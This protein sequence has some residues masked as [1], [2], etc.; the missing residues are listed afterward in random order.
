MILRPLELGDESAANRAQKILALEDFP[1]L[2]DFR[3][4]EAFDAY[5]ARVDAFNAGGRFSEG[6][7]PGVFLVAD[8][9]GEIVGRL[10]VRYELSDYLREFG[11]HIGYCVLPPHRRRGYAAQMLAAGLDLLWRR[12]LDEALV[13]CD[14]DNGGSIGVVEKAGGS[15][16]KTIPGEQ[17]GDVA[18]RHYI[19]HRDADRAAPGRI[20]PGSGRAMKGVPS[21]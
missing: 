10:S 4:G 21:T 6:G 19:F 9:D 7:V 11:G 5:V 2:F 3:I 12:G 17:S 13:T 1:F 8:C 15:H 14:D 18:K 16:A 20:E